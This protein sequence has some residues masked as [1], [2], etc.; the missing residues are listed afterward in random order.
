MAWEVLNCPIPLLDWY[1]RYVLSWELDQTLELPFVLEA[2]GQAL[3][4]A[5]PQI[6]NSDQGSQFTSPQWVSLL[7]EAGV[8]IIMDGKG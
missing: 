3:Q 5:T 7:Q 6:G 8:A 4:T 2:R 1:S